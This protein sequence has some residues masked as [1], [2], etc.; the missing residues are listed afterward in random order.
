MADAPYWE[1][2]HDPPI[3]SYENRFAIFRNPPRIG[4]DGYFDLP[5]GPGLGIELDESLLTRGGSQ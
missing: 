5:Q 2:L 3:G 1:L 4:S